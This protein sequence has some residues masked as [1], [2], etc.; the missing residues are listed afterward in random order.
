MLEQSIRVSP[1]YTAYASLAKN[2]QARGDTERWLATLERYLG[3]GVDTGLNEA[4]V[5]VDLADYYLAHGE[6]SRARAYSEAAAETWA[7]WAMECA[8]RVSEAMQDWP[9]A[10]VWYRAVAERYPNTSA[11]LW[12]CFCKRTGHGNVEAARDFVEEFIAANGDRPDLVDPENLGFF[13]W[14]SGAP[15][16]RWRTFARPTTAGARSRRGSA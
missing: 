16:K 1:D 15:P 5:R 14:I 13:H 12:Y 7:G 3:E 9:R 10:E 2:Y 6:L 4:R 8:G 11:Y